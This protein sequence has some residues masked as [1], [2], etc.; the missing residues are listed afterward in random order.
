[1]Y[2]RYIPNGSGYTR[3]AVEESPHDHGE[4]H[5]KQHY[6]KGK[7]EHL[8]ENDGIEHKGES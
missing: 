7:D 4:E 3:V 5:R 1:M 6:D 8:K 2:N